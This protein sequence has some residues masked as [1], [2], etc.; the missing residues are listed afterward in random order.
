MSGS[1]AGS[2]AVGVDNA[3]RPGAATRILGR[4]A[5]QVGVSPGEI[6]W[7]GTIVLLAA[8]L[9]FV[10]LPAR[11]GWDSDQA[12]SMFDLERALSSGRLPTFGPLSSLLTFHHGALYYDLL[13]PSAWLGG[14]DPT[15]VVGE[16]AL[17][18]LIVI[19][20]VW[21]MARSIAGPVAGLTAAFLAA[22]S[23]SM[24]G[25]ATFIWNPTMI[26]PGA[27]VAYA[28]AWQAL[29]TR[30]PG[31]WLVAAAGAAV[32]AQAHVAASVIV[33]PLAAAFVVDMWRGPAA[34]RLRIAIW[35]LAGV[36]LIVAT[37]LPLIV[38]ETGHDFSETRGI[39]DYF[40]G[41]GGLTSTNGPLVRLIFAAIRILAWPL[42]RWPMIDLIPAFVPALIAATA[43][44][45]LMIW[46]VGATAD[47]GR[48]AVRGAV[49]GAEAS[50]VAASE[51]ANES[52]TGPAVQLTAGAAAGLVRDPASD[53]GT[54]DRFGVRLM[55]FWLLL[56]VLVL[57][58][59][60]H[61]VSE[62]Q[63]LPTEQYH[64]MAD[65]L[66]FVAVGLIAGGLWQRLPRPRVNVARRAFVIGALGLLVAW[67]VGHWPPLTSPDGGWPAAQAAAARLQQDAA[68]SSMAV[69]PLFEPKGIDAYAYP[70]S[71]DGRVLVSSETAK[72]VVLLCD[73][74]WLEGQCSGSAEAGWLA[75]NPSPGGW[76]QVDR[77]QAA[78]DRL[79]SVYRRGP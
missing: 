37:Y 70:L 8:V 22:I 5:T 26:E 13:L 28:G 61:S 58:F 21:W 25:Y 7:L 66:V 68:G 45:A 67:N 33:V 11:G 38:Y 75:A 6:G 2:A 49:Q 32:T 34:R 77:F 30:R 14:G 74:F 73:S 78:P 50:P 64:A 40:V 76:I 79:L 46:L 42:T 44:S 41:G 52:A 17:L 20:A 9:R 60:L 59:G 19:P 55:G 27:A 31:W 15:W 10:N 69:V 36:A 29:R 3:S 53:G 24:I 23:A 56:I 35:G 18:S 72:T 16:I 65:P 47:S 51:P 71:R 39:L 43:V 48:R 12:T 63:E 62:V 4:L 54:I 1:Q 57:G